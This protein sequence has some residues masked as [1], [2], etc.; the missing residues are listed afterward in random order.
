MIGGGIIV[1][2]LLLLVGMM[3]DRAA[4]WVDHQHQQLLGGTSS[5]A[6][7]AS[8]SLV[9]SGAGGGSLYACA[10]AAG[11]DL[12]Q[13]VAF[14]GGEGGLEQHQYP[15]AGACLSVTLLLTIVLAITIC[16]T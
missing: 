10:R 11:C 15:Y 5:P 6:A 4:G 7:A 1:L 13:A 3:P 9:P 16:N 12:S 2:A 8:S 14:T